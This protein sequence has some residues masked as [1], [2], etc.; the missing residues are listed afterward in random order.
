MYKLEGEEDMS[1]TDFYVIWSAL[2][3]VFILVA[4]LLAVLGLGEWGGRVMAVL[5]FATSFFFAG[6]FKKTRKV[7]GILLAVFIALAVMLAML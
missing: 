4:E 7:V 6:A 5:L 3:G 2:R 1:A